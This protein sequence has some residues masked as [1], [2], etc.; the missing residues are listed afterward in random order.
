MAARPPVPPRPAELG[1]VGL[2]A[3]AAA[4]F[5]ATELLAGI[6]IGRFFDWGRAEALLFFVFRP[7]LLL[8]AAAAAARLPLR[9]RASLYAL[10]LLLAGLCETLLVVRLGARSPWSELSRGLAAGAAVAAVADALVQA[11][12]ARLGRWGPAAAALTGAALMLVPGALRPYDAIVLGPAGQVHAGPRPT[13]LLMTGLPLVWGDKGPFDPRSRPAAAYRELQKEF[14]LVPVDIL[15]QA[16]LGRGKLLFLAQPPRLSAAELAALDNWIRTGGRALILADPALLWPS[17][18]AL[19]DIRRPPPVSLVGPL[20]SHWGLSLQPPD[21]AGKAVEPIGRS[22]LAMAAPGRF[23]S[24]GRACGVR[25]GGRIARCG[26]GRGTALVIAD[27]DL[28]RDDLWTAPGAS[29]GERYRRTADNPAI[30]ADML[31]GLAGLSRP[32]PRVAWADPAASRG[33]ALAL[34]LLPIVA[35]AAAGLLLGNRGTG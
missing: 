26:L 5:A 25:Q 13:V 31:D 33:A 19:G 34:A 17:D 21:P 35:L 3:A 9:R 12:R 23:V 14:D 27:A 29:G 18:L 22:R 6:L 4:G 30:L 15:D 1:G 11:G 24:G 8:A 2:V 28:M 10:G 7:W 16:S 32:R 20:L